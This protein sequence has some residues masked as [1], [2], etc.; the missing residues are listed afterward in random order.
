MNERIIQK[1]SL[2]C[3]WKFNT[4]IVF[5]I[6][7]IAKESILLIDCSFQIN[8]HEGKKHELSTVSSTFD[9]NKG[10]RFHRRTEI[11]DICIN[12]HIEDQTEV[13]YNSSLQIIILYYTYIPSKHEL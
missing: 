13:V 5:C 9:Y 10:T 3:L 8:K 1:Q 2:F 6:L 7:L 12:C 11:K 4:F